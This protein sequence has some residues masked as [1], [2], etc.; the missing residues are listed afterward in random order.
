MKRLIF[1]LFSIVSSYMFSQPQKAFFVVHCDPNEAYNFSELEKMVDSANYYDISLTIE[2]TAPWVDSILPYQYRLNRITLWQV[3]GH[4]IAMHH[5][6]AEAPY[7]WDGYSN[8]SMAEIDEMG[9]D[10]LLFKGDCD[11]L[12]NRIQMITDSPIVTI[13]TEL[14]GEMPTNVLYQTRGQS[15]DSAYSNADPF[16]HLGNLYCTTT[17]SFLYKSSETE[18]NIEQNYADATDYNILGVVC[19]VYNFADFSSP[20][21][22]YFK[23]INENGIES[24][25]VKEIME[26][27]CQHNGNSFTENEIG[28]EIWPNPFCDNFKINYDSKKSNEYKV[29][30]YNSVGQLVYFE[31]ITE[32]IYTNS[33][34]KGLYLVKVINGK[35]IETFKIIKN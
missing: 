19:H 33:W 34:Q 13:G 4:E 35:N 20:S 18:F 28:I 17:H 32:I 7:F 11:S 1:I 26:E 12:Y 21:T 24:L 27:E 23:F 29:K 2:F 9:K 14:A 16:S 30:V 6:G 25:T 8:L 31:D 10:T 15:L 22:N 5:H 3:D